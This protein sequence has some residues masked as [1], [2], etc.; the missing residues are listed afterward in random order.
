MTW[1]PNVVG[2]TAQLR[3]AAAA[4]RRAGADLGEVRLRLPGEVWGAPDWL[5]ADAASELGYFR[6]SLDELRDELLAEASRLEMATN[7]PEPFFNIR[8]R[9][10]WT[11]FT[12][13]IRLI[14]ITFFTASGCKA[15]VSALLPPIPALAINMSIRSNSA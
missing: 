7:C 6:G 14:S 2:D 1:C 12:A 4:I 10:A 9:T 3:G 5:A 8:G 13:P 15:R 11:E